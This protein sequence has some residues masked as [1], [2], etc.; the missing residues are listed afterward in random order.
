[1]ICGFAARIVCVMLNLSLV[2]CGAIHFR[3]AEIDY[4]CRC[5]IS[6]RQPP[7]ANLP[8]EQRNDCHHRSGDDQR[9]RW[10]EVESNDRRTPAG[11]FGQTVS[12]RRQPETP[13][14]SPSRRPGERPQRRQQIAN[15]QDDRDFAGGLPTQEGAHHAHCQHGV[16][17]LQPSTG[18]TDRRPGQATH[19]QAGTQAGQLLPEQT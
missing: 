9:S 10:S 15:R 1:M 13:T 18:R 14:G 4:R 3:P 16:A 7:P 11:T 2:L 17:G 5:P 19:E 12:G 8:I 6:A